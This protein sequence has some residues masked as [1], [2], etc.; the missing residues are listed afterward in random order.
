VVVER[1]VADLPLPLRE[2]FVLTQVVG[3]SY[4]ETA[5]VLGC[6]IGTVRSRVYRARE[7]LVA[8]MGDGEVEQA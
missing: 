1:L 4:A 3:L 6:R 5:E 8:S 2:T 7:Q